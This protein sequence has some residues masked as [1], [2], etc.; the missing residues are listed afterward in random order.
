VGGGGGEAGG[1]W[2]R[3]K[4]A[5]GGGQHWAEGRNVHFYSG[6]QLGLCLVG[7]GALLG[8]LFS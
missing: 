6:S 7:C 1:T 3:T 5:G 4:G 2:G 8:C